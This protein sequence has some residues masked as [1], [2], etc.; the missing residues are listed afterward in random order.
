MDYGKGWGDPTKYGVSEGW[1]FV[2]PDR[3]RKHH[4]YL[5]C[6]ECDSEQS[7]VKYGLGTSLMLGLLACGQ[8]SAS[9]TPMGN[10]RSA[11]WCPDARERTQRGRGA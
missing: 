4:F 3:E 9:P 11:D 2:E 10:A 7:F 5:R 6:K 1:D 8:R